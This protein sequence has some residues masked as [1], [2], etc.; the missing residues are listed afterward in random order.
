MSDRSELLARI[1]AWVAGDPDAECRA[2]IA[3]LVEKA[4]LGRVDGKADGAAGAALAELE[5]RFADALRFGTAGLRGA[6]AA[7]PNRMNRAVVIRAARGLADYLGHQG[8]EGRVPRVVIGNDARHHSREFARDSAAVVV[9]AGGE[10]L[11]LPDQVPTPVLAFAVRRLGADAG[12]MVTASHNPACDNGYKVYLGG[13][14]VTDPER[15]VQIVPPYDTQIAACIEAV[16]PANEVPRAESGWVD[17]GP[18]LVEA[19]V[20]AIA[21]RGDGSNGL[22]GCESLGQPE[23][24]F[25]PSPDLPDG[26]QGDGSSG[27]WHSTQPANENGPEEPSPGSPGSEEPSPE[28]LPAPIRIVHT[29]MHGVGSGIALE[30]LRRCGFEDVVPVPEQREP[31]PDFP[32]VAF[33]N[34]EEPGAID[35]AV[36]LARRVDA[37][38]V[39]ANDPDAD[40]CAVAVLDQRE[41]A[42]GGWRML[43]GDEL[44]SVL[45]EDAASRIAT[46]GDSPGNVPSVPPVLVDSLVSSRLLGEI[47]A[48]HG[49]AYRR[50]LTGF[51][52]MGRVPGLAY[53]YEEAIGYCV[54]PDLVHDKDGLSTGL[55]VARLVARLKAQGRTIVDVLDDLARAHNLHLSGQLAVRFADPGQIAATVQRLREAPPAAIAGSP[56]TQVADLAGGYDDLPPTDG[57]LLLTARDDRVIVRPSGTEPKVKC[58]LEVIM[59]VAP[60]ASFDDLTAIRARATERVGTI[61]ADLDATVFAKS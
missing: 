59:P 43:H 32:T 20:A 14:A 25:E 34:P 8:W 26:G 55:A 36:A 39:I 30:S 48:A 37:D 33:P 22:V 38:V 57:V 13:R 58:Y 29:A 11:L 35:L 9:A 60:D 19:Y 18:E 46:E 24:P 7:G 41:Q 12:V 23:G 2:E 16:G 1:S 52:W 15:G 28:V 5:D 21:G 50:T 17:V 6:M 10:A 45:G 3:A 44:G 53:A 31:D 49:V 4:G 56:V 61:K 27:P 40:R 54:R 51:K 47:A 42:N